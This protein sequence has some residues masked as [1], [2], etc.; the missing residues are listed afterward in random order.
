MQRRE[1]I[2]TTAAGALLP[3]AVSKAI[4]RLPDEKNP[5]VKEI[6][7]RIRPV[8]AEERL[9]R[10]EN[11]RKLMTE[12][13]IDALIL[14][15]GTRM[16]YFSGVNWG[17]S[18]RLFAMILPKKGE[19]QFIAPKFEEARAREQVGSATLLTC[20]EDESPYA[21][22]KNILSGAGA[23]TGTLAIEETPR[24][25]VTENISGAISGAT[26]PSLTPFPPASLSAQSHHHIP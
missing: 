3:I 16:N 1:F 26:L 22:I 5:K 2:R 4:S 19:A 18:E 7:D 21:L 8:T 13:G 6:R 10:Q 15:G 11:A 20:E 24:H 23:T 17:R 9:L 12:R 14:E 25:F